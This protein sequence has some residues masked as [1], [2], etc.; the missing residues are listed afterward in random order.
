M[1]T[2]IAGGTGRLFDEGRWLVV[3]VLLPVFCFELW[4][5]LTSDRAVAW[6]IFAPLNV[7]LI[8][9]GDATAT[10][11]METALLGAAANRLYSVASTTLL[12]FVSV[13]VG[14]YGWWSLWRSPKSRR[15]RQVVWGLS[16]A[17]L[18]I[19]VHALDGNL[20]LEKLG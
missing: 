1:A 15:D 8:E 4:S 9:P 7:K 11:S 20:V 10:K 12:V 17:V 13:G 16:A 14:A 5:T 2:G 3:L 18:A 6:G 19:V